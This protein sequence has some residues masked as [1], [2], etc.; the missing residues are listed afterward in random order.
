VIV[1]LSSYAKMC[2]LT[3]SPHGW[4]SE[5]ETGS[6]RDGTVSGHSRRGI[7]R[8]RY[9]IVPH[10]KRLTAVIDVNIGRLLLWHVPARTRTYVP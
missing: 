8:A 3:A 7:V 6:V 5:G 9:G 10:F 1:Q 4:T 2:H